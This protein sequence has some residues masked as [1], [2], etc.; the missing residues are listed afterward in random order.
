MTL[1]MGYDVYLPTLPNASGN[2]SSTAKDWHIHFVHFIGPVKLF[3]SWPKGYHFTKL[4]AHAWNE[5]D[6]FG[7]DFF[8]QD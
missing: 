5:N 1:A 6:N 4:D 8:C 3:K 7:Y 2:L